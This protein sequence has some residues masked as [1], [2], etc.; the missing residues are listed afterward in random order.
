MKKILFIILS[1][2]LV[3]IS[4]CACKNP[5]EN[6]STGDVAIELVLSKTEKELLLGEEYELM[7][8]S[9]AHMSQ[10]ITWTSSNSTVATVEN[11]KIVANQVGETLITATAEDGKTATCNIYVVTG[12]RLP[13]LEFEFDYE[14]NISV[15]LSEKLNFDGWVKFNGTKF[16]DMEISYQLSNQTIGTIDSEGTFSPLEKGTTTVTIKAQWRN[17]QSE[18]LTKTFTVTVI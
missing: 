7:V 10:T 11:G 9:E 8:Y 15:N 17:V 6:S 16:F 2:V 4:V 18:L 3:L 12:G 14:E 13:V 5:N 1:A